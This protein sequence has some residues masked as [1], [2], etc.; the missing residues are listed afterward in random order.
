M[1]SHLAELSLELARA[2]QA[3]GVKAAK[4]GDLDRAVKAECTWSV[5]VIRPGW[6]GM[7]WDLAGRKLQQSRAP[8]TMWNGIVDAVRQEY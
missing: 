3:Q 2:V 1:L 6:C 5:K 4:A 8:A 7:N